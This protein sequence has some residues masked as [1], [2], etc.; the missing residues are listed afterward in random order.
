MTLLIV[1]GANVKSLS[2]GIGCVGGVLVAGGLAVIMDKFLKLTGIINEQ[3][4]FL[5]MLNP[6]HP[7]D[8]K[9]II[10]ASIIIGAVGAIMDVAIS[11]ASSL[12][13]IQAQNADISFRKLYT[14]GITIGRDIMGTMTNTLILAYIGSSLSV[15]L[16]LTSS[17]P[18]LT[19]MLN[20]EMIIVEM[21]QSLVGSMGILLTLPLTS[22]I[23]AFLYTK[24]LKKVA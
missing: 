1:N 16:L 21:L 14:S 8:L 18:S 19:Y 6:E 22:L 9:A 12:N 20:T 7:I 24:K 2:A 4:V 5:Q 11:I 17:A 15:V 3:S 13:E 23:S 10:F